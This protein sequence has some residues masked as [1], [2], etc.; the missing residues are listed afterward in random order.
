MSTDP[1]PP[2]PSA[3]L[4]P[5]PRDS[6]SPP[7]YPTHGGLQSAGPPSAASGGLLDTLRVGVVMLDTRGRVVLWSPLAEEMLGWAGEHI[8]GRRLETIITPRAGTDAAEDREGGSGTTGRARSVQG[9][10]RDISRSRDG[11]DR[12]AGGAA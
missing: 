11:A 3:K 5:P 12:D 7:P 10:D 9:G 1:E 2:R 4:P 6:H 8:V